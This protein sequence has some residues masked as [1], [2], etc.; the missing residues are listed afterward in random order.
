MSC[1]QGQ[2]GIQ[3]NNMMTDGQLEQRGEFVTVPWI[4]WVGLVCFVLICW[5]HPYQWRVSVLCASL[6]NTIL[7]LCS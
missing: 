3:V 2:P 7:E 1:Y 4:R 5:S 6:S